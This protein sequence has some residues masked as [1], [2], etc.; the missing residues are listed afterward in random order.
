[1]SDEQ[2]LSTSEMSPVTFG[3][4]LISTLELFNDMKPE[5]MEKSTE[6]WSSPLGERFSWAKGGDR[7]RIMSCKH[8][9]IYKPTVFFTSLMKPNHVDCVECGFRRAVRNFRT[10][11]TVCDGCHESGFTEL[12]AVSYQAG[13]FIISGKICDVCHDKQ[14]VPEEPEAQE[15]MQDEANNDQ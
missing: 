14:P 1:M 2:V 5:S 11:P 15:E 7:R 8:V 3:N 13:M 6:F 4:M 10:D 9:S 12:R